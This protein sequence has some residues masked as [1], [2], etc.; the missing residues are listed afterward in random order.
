MPKLCSP[1]SA[2]TAQHCIVLPPGAKL[3]EHLRWR[4]FTGDPGTA[5][6]G[7]PAGRKGLPLGRGA[8]ETGTAKF[9]NGHTRNLGWY[10]YSPRTGATYSPVTG[11]SSGGQVIGTGWTAV[12]VIAAPGLAGNAGSQLNGPLKAL[13]D[14][15][16]AVH[17]SW[18]SGHLLRTSLLSVLITSKGQ[19]LVG[20]VTPDLLYTDVAKAK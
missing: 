13:L 10:A 16:T 2:K 1:A 8:P 18:G 15:A 17:G 12:R 20:A 3:P 9:G 4:S 19:V 7:V 11:D 6:I 5:R 14:S